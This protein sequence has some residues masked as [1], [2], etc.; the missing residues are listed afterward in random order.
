[1]RAGVQEVA[2]YQAGPADDDPLLLLLHGFSDDINSYEGVIPRLADRHER[3]FLVEQ[4]ME[5]L[6]RADPGPFTM[7]EATEGS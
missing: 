6:P 2:Y 3:G 7:S 4:V 5:L 1:M